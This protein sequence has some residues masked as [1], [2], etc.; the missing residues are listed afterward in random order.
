MMEMRKLRWEDFDDLLELYETGYTEIK[1]NKDYGDYVYFKKPKLSFRMEKFATDYKNM[2]KGNILFYVA[3]VNGKV[4]G[5]CVVRKKDI[6]DSEISHIGILSIRMAKE[7]R[8]KGIGTKLLKYTIS[9]CKDK[10]E[11]LEAN[12]FFFNK[13]SV[14]LFKK[15]GF[16]TW[17]TAPRYVKRGKRYI[18]VEYMSLRL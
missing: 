16:E 14:S 11:I 12:V 18:D 2:I 15:F 6:P 13:T 9:R 7:W 5:F 1:S 10:F 17:G 4:V 3:E 8:G